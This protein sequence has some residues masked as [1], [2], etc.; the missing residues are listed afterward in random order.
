MMARVLAL[1]TCALLFLTA[2]TDEDPAT[3]NARFPDAEGV[4]TSVSFEEIEIDGETR[5]PIDP[6][7]QSFSTYNA[8][9]IPLLSW[10]NKYVHL[11]LD[12]GQVVWVAGIGVVDSKADPPTVYYVGG[13]LV[14][15]DKNKAIFQDGTV[16]TLAEG[17]EPPEQGISVLA[18]I[19]VNQDK[20][21]SLTS[22]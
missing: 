21:V 18:L 6:E 12:D 13:V 22:Q 9:V 15:V 20:V 2:C 8:N 4:V 17:V 5:Y 11:G 3:A 14:K 16:L 7:V 10:Q 1:V 19:D